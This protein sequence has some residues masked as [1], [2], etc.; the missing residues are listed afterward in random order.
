MNGHGPSL[1]DGAAPTFLTSGPITA[2][3]F[4]PISQDSQTPVSFTSEQIGVAR[5]NLRLQT[6]HSWSACS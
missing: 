3:L 5:S 2:Q 1:T 4:P 6:Y